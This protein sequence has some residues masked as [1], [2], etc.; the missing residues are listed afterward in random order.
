MS[1]ALHVDFAKLRRLAE[2]YQRLERRPGIPLLEGDEHDAWWR[3]IQALSPADVLALLDRLENAEWRLDLLRA[4]I[5]AYAGREELLAIL[6]T[7]EA[8][9][10]TLMTQVSKDKP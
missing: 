6:S 10:P 4:R 1:T 7:S 9:Y 2:D 8:I 3:L 5:H